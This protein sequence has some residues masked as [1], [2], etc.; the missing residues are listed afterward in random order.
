M[1]NCEI[2]NYT[3]GYTP[4]PLNRKTI[5]F[6]TDLKDHSSQLFHYTTELAGRTGSDIICLHVVDKYAH[7]AYLGISGYYLSREDKGKIIAR[8]LDSRRESMSRRFSESAY[9]NTDAGGLFPSDNFRP[10]IKSIVRFGNIVDEILQCSVSMNCDLIVMGSHAASHSLLTT[11]L[12]SLA[13][14]RSG[15]P[16]LV[17]PISK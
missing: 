12:S 14:K 5:L 17:V 2:S 6:T 13:L 4:P 11:H 16:I 10:D 1:N 9:T 8:E 3:G 7:N 15:I